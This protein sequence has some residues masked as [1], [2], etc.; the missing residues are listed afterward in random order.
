VL[1]SG[2]ALINGLPAQ[3]HIEFTSANFKELDTSAAGVFEVYLLPDTYAIKATASGTERGVSVDY[4]FTQTSSLTSS[5]NLNLA[6]TKVP[7][8]QVGVTWDSNEKQ[9]VAPGTTVVYNIHV[10]NKG[11][12]ADTYQLTAT[13]P[14]GWT[15]SFSNSLVDVDFGTANSQ[16][17][18]L[19]IHTP[20][21]AKV[22][23][24]TTTIR[25][26]STSGSVATNTVSVD[27]GILPAHGVTLTY[28]KAL[29]TTGQSYNF[30]VALKNTGNIDDTYAVSLVNLAEL[31]GFG[32]K[33]EI[34]SGSG[35]FASNLTVAVKAGNSNDLT[36]RLTPIRANPE[37][38]VQVV[39]SAT[40][41]SSTTT[42]NVLAFNPDLPKLSIQG[43]FSVSGEGVTNS[44]PAIPVGTVVLAALVLAMMTILILVSIQ[45]GVF[46]RGKR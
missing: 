37:P 1:I 9:T 28:T 33:A 41:Q 45:K 8:H 20:A 12:V 13:L 39:I 11:N 43:G 16:L 44:V 27:V 46:R 25:A 17:V 19:T 38:S 30:T 7:K 24:A 29:P 23:H 22:T 34:M 35:A 6:L 32:W 31:N 10:T 4:K 40:S 21:D 18:T 42:S 3:A 2:N 14:T 26:V 15:G 5:Q 36:L